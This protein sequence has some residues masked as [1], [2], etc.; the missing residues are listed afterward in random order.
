LRKRLPATLEDQ[1]QRFEPVDEC[2]VG[3][4]KEIEWGTLLNLLGKQ[5]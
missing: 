2:C 3:G 5:A 4:S 1:V